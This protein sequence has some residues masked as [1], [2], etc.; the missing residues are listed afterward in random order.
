MLNYE[1]PPIG[2]GGGVISKE[3][4][5]GLSG[6]GHQITIVTTWFKGLKEEERFTENLL[7][8]RIKA[9]RKKSFQSNPLEMADWVIKTKRF[10]SLLLQN[11]SF[12]LCFANFVMPGGEVALFLKKKFNLPFVVI[13]HGHDIPWVNAQKQWPLYAAAFFRIKG[14]LKEASKVFIQTTKMEKNLLKFFPSANYSII[15]NGVHLV[16]REKKINPK[17]F[18][19]IAVGRLVTQKDPETYLL[20]FLDFA[21]HKTEV[22]LLIYGDGPK[23]KKL[24]GLVKKYAAH[25]KV[26]L[27]G[28]RPQDEV[29]QSMFNATVYL[30]S[31]L[32]E[33]MSLAMLEA[34]SAGIPVITTPVSGT[35]EI[36][37]SATGKFVNFRSPEEIKNLLED[38]FLKWREGTL[39]YV[40]NEDF[41]KNYS[42]NEISKKYHK[43]ISSLK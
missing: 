13:S 2:G 8:L 40:V 22:K 28:K 9:L 21:K 5:L 36:I 30:S 34:I 37:N 20:G 39:E 31:S 19:V 15:P 32:N 16:D 4:A 23:R 10:T 11:Q 7:V 35:E 18:S 25:E 3:I 24:K 27:F 29:I 26:K 1:F 14:V 41:V 17:I 43:E 33:G 12:D 6:L 38:Y 42:W